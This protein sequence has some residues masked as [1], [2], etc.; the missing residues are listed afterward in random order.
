MVGAD[1]VV[2]EINA[3][4]DE[5]R[6]LAREDPGAFER[7]RG[8]VAL[9]SDKVDSKSGEIATDVDADAD[10]DE[11]AVSDEGDVTI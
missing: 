7:F 5:L 1:Q 3:N 8:C 2:K 9:K 6:I 11:V 4:A 10:A